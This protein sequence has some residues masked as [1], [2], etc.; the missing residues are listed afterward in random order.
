M[1][2]INIKPSLHDDV[3]AGS[4]G[5]H[6]IARFVRFAWRRVLAA[7][8]IA[9]ALGYAYILMTPRT[10]MATAVVLYDPSTSPTLTQQSRWLESSVEMSTRIESQVEILKSANVARQVIEKLGLTNDTEFTA[11]PS[12]SARLRA[13]ILSLAGAPSVGAE[14]MGPGAPALDP[15]LVVPGFLRDLAVRRVGL[16]SVLEVS[17]RAGDPVKAALI[18]NTVARRY[19]GLDLEQKSQA[20]LNRSEWLKARLEELRKQAFE[21]TRE[22]ELFK[23]KGGGGLA[24]EYPVRLAELESIAQT[25]RRMYETLLSQVTD[26]QQRVSY[27]VGDARMVSPAT[28]SR[29]TMQPNT[30]IVLAFAGTAGAFLSA[31]IALLQ[32][33]LDR[34]VRSPE[35]LSADGLACLGALDRFPPRSRRT[36]MPKSMFAGAARKPRFRLSSAPPP[37]PAVSWR[38]ESHHLLQLLQIK[39]AIDACVSSTGRS[40]GLVGVDKGAGAS[41]LAMLLAGRY[42]MAGRRTLLVDAC[43]G[44]ADVSRL[45]APNACGGLSETILTGR[46]RQDSLVAQQ[47]PGLFVL[48]NGRASLP[49]SPGELLGSPA[50]SLKLP[51]LSEGFDTVLVDLPPLSRS[52]DAS[53]IGSLLDAVVVV[54]EHGVTQLPDLK[55]QIAAMQ[56]TGA[57]VIGVVLNKWVAI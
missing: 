34:R 36:S 21:A 41:S 27:P 4:L 40:I 3:A 7:T 51:Q 47:T 53:L 33:A 31:L 1:D 22:V 14:R 57:R 6:E 5:P 50:S 44:D 52:A 55:S 56:G 12:L 46:V 26:M 49:V 39:T 9:V 19:I 8:L 30:R 10:F 37:L 48:A 18:A 16:S 15:E 54:A 29:V 32:L 11:P 38:V 45:L 13:A 43:A 17:F 2:M 20:A 28:P 25:Y 23:L 24:A 42:A 35:S